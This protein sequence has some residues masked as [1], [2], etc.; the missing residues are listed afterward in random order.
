MSVQRMSLVSIVTPSY[1]QRQYLA[2]MLDSIHRQDYPHIEHI[3]MDGGSTD[4]TQAL[5][6]AAPYRFAWV[7]APDRGQA[8]AINQGFA[9]ARGE[10]FGWLNCD[11]LYVPGAVRT[12]VEYF[13]AHPEAKLV[14]GDALAIDARGRGYGL[15]TNVRPCDAAQLI[16]RGDFIVQP[17]AF[18]RAELWRELGALDETLHYVLDYEYWMRAARRYPLHYLPVCV[19]KERIHQETKTANGHLTRIHEL[20]TVARRYGGE[21]VPARFRAEAAAMH[22]RQG[23]QELRAGRWPQARQHFAISVNLRPHWVKYLVYMV[24]LGLFGPRSLAR[25]RLWAN[26]ARSWR[27]PR[28]PEPAAGAAHAQATD[29]PGP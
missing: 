29:G 16:R 17:A 14:Y 3:I 1:N 27:R 26:R 25:L 18:W 24:S 13:A 23:L 6:Q 4:G 2:Q 19:A 15:R 21:G 8:D 7:S 22:S 20:Y 5:L 12:V 28:Y 10:I 9:A 11:D